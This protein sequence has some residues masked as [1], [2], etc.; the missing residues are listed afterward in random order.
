M[1]AKNVLKRHANMIATLGLITFQ[2]DTEHQAQ[3]YGTLFKHIK[4][5]C[6]MKRD[7][8]ESETIPQHQ[9]LRE[10]DHITKW[11]Y[12]P[13]RVV[14]SSNDEPRIYYKL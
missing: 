10:L 5:L 7:K 9:N 3:L 6:I 2:I 8:P 13:K 4:G 11:N 12:L 1:K 14:I